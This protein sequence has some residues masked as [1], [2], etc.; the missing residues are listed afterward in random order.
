MGRQGRKIR[1][2]DANSIVPGRDAERLECLLSISFTLRTSCL[3]ILCSPVVSL[4]R[5]LYRR[6]LRSFRSVSSRAYRRLES[7][8]RAASQLD[9]TRMLDR[10]GRT[11]RRIVQG[12][13]A[14]RISFAQAILC[15]SLWRPEYYRFIFFG[16]VRTS[17][18]QENLRNWVRRSE[19]S[20]RNSDRF[21]GNAETVLP[22]DDQNSARRASRKTWVIG[23]LPHQT[24]PTRE[25][26]LKRDIS[27]HNGIASGSSAT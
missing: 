13:R 23:N 7:S 9:S 17:Y 10:S 4:S 11:P 24:P 19:L 5:S 15:S 14:A 26:Y 3:G 21:F 12:L 22:N 27:L 6:R 18:P 20:L 2:R 25:T 16:V 8:V 1:T